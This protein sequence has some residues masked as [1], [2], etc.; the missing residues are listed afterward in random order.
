MFSLHKPLGLPHLEA[1]DE[2]TLKTD[3]RI[4]TVLCICACTHTIRKDGRRARQ[5]DKVVGY[6]W[7]QVMKATK[8]FPLGSAAG[9]SGLCPNHIYEL[10]KVQDFGHGSTFISAMTRFVNLFLSG[11][12]PPKLAPWLCGAPLTALQKRNGGIRPITAG[13]TLR[14]LIT[15][16][17]MNHISKT[18]A[19]WFHPLQFGIATRNGTEAV[20]HAVRKV[21]QHDG[22]NS[23]YGLLSVDLTNAFN[24]VSRNAFLKGLK[25]HLPSLLACT[26]YC[27][28]G[29]APFLWRGED[30]IWSVRGVQQGDPLGPL[31]FAIALP[32][33]AADLRK[34][35]QESESS[36]D[37]SLLLA[38][39]S[40]VL[41]R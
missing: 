19:N 5:I 7:P 30:S 3:S 15:S 2:H 8:T 18:A 37:S 36:A 27:C 26:S 14:R 33:I 10:S 29:E 17:A 4:R 31:L 41:P 32:P 23:E 6:C 13:E 40:Y 22:S 21:M 24:L 25:D 11:K 39:V 20:V 34:R 12:S 38:A 28:D 1:Q 16:R 35:L 9:G